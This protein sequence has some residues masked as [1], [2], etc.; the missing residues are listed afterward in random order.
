MWVSRAESPTDSFSRPTIT[1]NG[2][3]LQP[4]PLLGAKT[5]P[6]GLGWV[7]AGALALQV[8]LTVAEWEQVFGEPEELDDIRAYDVAQPHTA[9][10]RPFVQAV[11]QIE[12]DDGE[13][14]TE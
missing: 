11:H 2:S 9:D 10:R 12:R 3:G 7:V 8:P 13:E 6:V 14:S 1:L 5:Q 4:L